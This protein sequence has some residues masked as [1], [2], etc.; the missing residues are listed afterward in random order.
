MGDYS[1][2]VTRLGFGLLLALAVLAQATFFPALH[3]LSIGP[4][5]AL[6]LI[7]LWSATRGA[8]EGLIWALGAGL[9]LD[10]VS[11]DPLGFNAL[12]LLPAALL[13]GLARHRIVHSRVLQPMILVT[14]A[15]VAHWLVAG[16]V[17][18]LLGAGYALGF[19]LRLGLLTAAINLA[20]V[21]FLF[22]L[23][24][25]LERLGVVRAAPI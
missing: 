7:L 19:S 24:L 25:I 9:L 18:A 2:T 15:T 4:N 16:F 22:A 8:P 17:G 5:L 6:V 1:E 21:P 3:I 14:G 23:T 12:A 10:L 20:T 11:L 13:G